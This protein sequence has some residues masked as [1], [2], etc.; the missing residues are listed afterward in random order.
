V[1]TP[2]Q[3]FD[4]SGRLYGGFWQ[5]LKRERRAGDMRKKAQDNR[6]SA[7]TNG[8]MEKILIAYL[9]LGDLMSILLRQDNWDSAFG[10]VFPTRERLEYDLQALV[11]KHKG[12]PDDHKIDDGGR[13]SHR[14]SRVGIPRRRF[15]RD[16]TL[17]QRRRRP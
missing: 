16:Q 1:T 13:L 7:M 11:A 3:R 14:I 10:H 4:L 8:E 6:A 5:N 9:D 12:N 17:G 15:F 2:S